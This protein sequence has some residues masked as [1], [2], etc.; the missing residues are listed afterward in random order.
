MADRLLAELAPLP[1]ENLAG[2]MA[3]FLEIGI[4]E[5]EDVPFR[6]CPAD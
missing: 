2:V 3:L 5:N 4:A 6:V 1:P